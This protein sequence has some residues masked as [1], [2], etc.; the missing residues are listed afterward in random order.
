MKTQFIVTQYGKELSSSKYTWDD[1]TKTFSSEENNLVLVFETSRVTFKT[2]YNC[3]F[4]TGGYCTFD[5]GSYCT[6][7]TGS[8]CTFKT[9]F[10]C[11]FKT[12][13]ECTFDTSANCTFDTGAYCIFKTCANCTF[14]TGSNCTFDTSN[15]CTFNTGSNCVIIRRDIF[16]IIHPDN[17]V[18]IKLNKYLIKGFSK[19]KEKVE[20]TL[21]EVSDKL[22]IPL[23]QLRI[24]D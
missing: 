20:L 21:K 12:G 11:T 19:V 8:S 22:G 6:F 5:T 1:D 13:A 3:T 7:D 24:K 9:G 2:G 15:N 18:E 4:N 14:K 10:N 16:E 23:D 17:G